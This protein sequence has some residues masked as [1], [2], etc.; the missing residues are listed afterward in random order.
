MKAKNRSF[1]EPTALSYTG[2]GFPMAGARRTLCLLAL[3]GG[4]NSLLTGSLKSPCAN[5]DG[6]PGYSFS[7]NGLWIP[8]Y[9]LLGTGFTKQTCSAEC[10]KLKSCVAFSGAF[11]EYGGN[12]GCYTYTAT[13]GNVRS[14]ADRAYKKCQHASQEPPADL[15]GMHLVARTQIT[16]A[17]LVTMAQGMEAQLDVVSKTMADADLRMRRLKS[18][19]AGVANIFVDQARIATVTSETAL[20]NRGGLLSIARSKKNIEFTIPAIKSGSTGI[21]ALLK[22]IGKGKKVATTT[23]A[24]KKKVALATKNL[25]FYDSNVTALEKK[26]NPLNDGTVFKEI[27]GLVTAYKGLEEK[28]GVTV[29]QVLRSELRGLVDTQREA[30]HNYTDALANIKKDGCCVK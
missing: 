7:H 30:F 17:D 26:L 29:K 27:K 24:P 12:G 4:A 25:G 14:G 23:G 16:E 5:S 11:K 8:G 22:R 13:G 3:V 2:L 1:A 28:I 6:L 9:H 20:G 21:D 15:V 10:S 19:V 18:M